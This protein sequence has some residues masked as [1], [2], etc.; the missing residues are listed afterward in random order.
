MPFSEPWRRTALRTGSIAL[1]IGLGVGLYRHRLAVVP[2]VTLV[3]LWFTLGGHFVELLFRNGIDPRLGEPAQ[4]RA[5]VR[6]AY[7]F[8]AGSVLYAGALATRGILTGQG[9]VLWPWWTGGVVFVALE[10]LIHLW[11]RLRR[12]PSF[13]DGRG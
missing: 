7:W 5:L 10:L 2:L 11:M 12:Q 3:A 4:R 1:G 9:A 6:L 13:Y 8:V